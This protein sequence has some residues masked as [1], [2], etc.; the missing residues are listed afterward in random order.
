MGI[1][2]I[3]EV[4]DGGERKIGSREQILRGNSSG[5]KVGHSQRDTQVKSRR[6][7]FLFRCPHIPCYLAH[8][9]CLDIFV[10]W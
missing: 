2:A 7:T 6:Q 4:G 10:E 3:G 8:S 9:R 5:K 1:E